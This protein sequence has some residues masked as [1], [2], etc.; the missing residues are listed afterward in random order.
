MYSRFFNN[1][2]FFS[3][4]ILLYLFLLHLS[5]QPVSQETLTRRTV[6]RCQYIKPPA[7]QP[8]SLSEYILSKPDLERCET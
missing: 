3:N 6:K 1:Y 7:S 2:L 5:S 4:K 8:F